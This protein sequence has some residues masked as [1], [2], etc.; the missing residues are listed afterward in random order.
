MGRAGQCGPSDG[1]CL[2]NPGANGEY[3]DHLFGGKDEDVIDW[4]P[5]GVYGPGT[6]RTCIVGP[7]PAATKKGGPTYDPCTWFEMTDRAD[8]VARRVSSLR[9]TSTTRASTGSTVAGTAT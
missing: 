7:V 8:D 1:P 9:T 3:V 5:R 4:R 6:A 2:E